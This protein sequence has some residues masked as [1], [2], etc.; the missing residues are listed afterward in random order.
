M[1]PICSWFAICSQ[2]DLGTGLFRP[3]VAYFD[4]G[5][6]LSLKLPALKLLAIKDMKHP[7]KCGVVGLNYV[8]DR[9]RPIRENRNDEARIFVT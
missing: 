8:A 2:K 7:R 1:Y 5:S 6:G 4:F 3:L 9:P